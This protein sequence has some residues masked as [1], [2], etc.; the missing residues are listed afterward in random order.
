M[1]LVDALRLD[2]IFSDDRR[3]S[4]ADAH[5][6]LFRRARVL[7]PKD[8]LLLELAYKNNLSIRQIARILDRPA[9]SVSRKMNRLRARLHDPMVAALA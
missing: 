4:L 1:P 8:R 5:E 9:G 7:A 2:Q 3:P 6:V